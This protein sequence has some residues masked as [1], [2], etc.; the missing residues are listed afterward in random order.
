LPGPRVKC[1]VN[2]C[3]HWVPGDFCAAGNID[4]LN[5][6]EGKMSHHSE[7]T[8]CKTFYNRRSLANIMGSLDNVNWGGML[9]EPFLPGQQLTPTVTCVVESCRY[10]S[11]GNRCDAEDIEVSGREAN[12]CQDTNCETFEPR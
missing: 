12:E 1:E 10:W 7:Q 8:E 11:N 9:S 3:T 2:T 4:I 6:E 5:E